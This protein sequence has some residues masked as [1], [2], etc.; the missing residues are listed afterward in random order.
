MVPAALK[1]R[2]G[3]DFKSKAIRFRVRNV[4]PDCSLEF[5][6]AVECP[7]VS[8]A[9]SSVGV[10]LFPG[11]I[12]FHHSRKM[13]FSSPALMATCCLVA[14]KQLLLQFRSNMTQHTPKT[15]LEPKKFKQQ[16][17]IR[18]HRSKLLP[19]ST[20]L[21]WGRRKRFTVT[22]CYTA[23]NNP[24]NNFRKTIRLIYLPLNRK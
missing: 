23:Q 12:N 4:P 14:H 15:L 21:R 1:T 22:V 5:A 17:D 3:P 2:A 11:F 20:L 9:F 10:E 7:S 13:R 16:L 24:P 18:C 6:P 8:K 19:D